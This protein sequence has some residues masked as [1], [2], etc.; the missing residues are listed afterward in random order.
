MKGEEDI[1]EVTPES[2]S[3]AAPAFPKP[4]G[5]GNVVEENADDTAG[6][7]GTEKPSEEVEKPEGIGSQVLEDART[8]GFATD[9][10]KDLP[11]Q[12]VQQMVRSTMN[13]MMELSQRMPPPP[14]H[15]AEEKPKVKGFIDLSKH[16]LT[17]ANESLVKALHDINEA[18]AT[19]LESREKAFKEE[20]H[21]REITMLSRGLDEVVAELGS[22]FEGSL[23]KGEV[24][25][26][27]QAYR[28]RGQVF[29][30]A[31]GLKQSYELNGMR[32]PEW[33]SLVKMV[34]RANFWDPKSA[35]ANARKE[36]EAEVK[37]TGK[38]VIGQPNAMQAS[39]SKDPRSRAISSMNAVRKAKGLPIE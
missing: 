20:N 38:K 6:E 30:L 27:S 33:S 19:Q 9:D 1:E 11:P 35:K 8:L 31:M 16:D 26:G 34:A 25:E 23:G 5:D 3:E 2:T 15:Q 14:T 29:T 37:R 13:R 10:L 39:K 17:D 24:S 22:E 21:A 18:A 36:V 7:E 32:A 28:N 12:A 4:D